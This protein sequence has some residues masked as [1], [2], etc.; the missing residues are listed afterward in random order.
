MSKLEYTNP[1]GQSAEYLSEYF[2]TPFR[3]GYVNC[4]NVVLPQYFTMFGDRIKDME[5][6][7]DDTWVCSF[8]KSGEHAT[9]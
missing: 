2:T 8:P 9:D 7:P 5:I 3:T 1:S 6:R 4:K